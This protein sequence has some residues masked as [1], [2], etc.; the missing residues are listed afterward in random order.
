[1][2]VGLF[3]AEGFFPDFLL[4]LKRGQHQVLA[5]VEPKGLR[6]QWP[7]DK[8]R[9]LEDVVPTWKFSVPICGYVLS[10]NT[11]AELRKIQPDFCWGNPKVLL[12][13]DAQGGYVE[14]LLRNMLELL[15][16]ST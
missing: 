5:F 16:E 15:P 11:E 14:T 12:Q 10:G 2:G 7:A 8:F 1:V 3:A 4:W 13:Q 6:H 9:L